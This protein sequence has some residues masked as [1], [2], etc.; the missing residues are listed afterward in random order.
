MLDAADEVA[1]VRSYNII[2]TP[3]EP[4]YD[5]IAEMPARAAGCPAGLINLLDDKN[6]CPLRS[7][8][9]VGTEGSNSSSV[10]AASRIA[11][12]EFLSP[13]VG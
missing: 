7:S 9:A 3:P 11:C 12:Q 1:A 2:G 4:D 5:R 6:Q 10:Q 13:P 8:P